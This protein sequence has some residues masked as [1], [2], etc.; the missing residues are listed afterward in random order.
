MGNYPNNDT[1]NRRNLLKSTTVAASSLFALGGIGSGAAQSVPTDA[2][3]TVDELALEYEVHPS[4][5][6]VAFTSV[7]EKESFQ[8]YVA[9][10]VRSV[11]DVPDTVVR[12]TD[13]EHG[14]HGLSWESRRVLQYSRDG[15]TYQQHIGS[16]RSSR[17]SRA[18]QGREILVDEEPATITSTTSW[19]TS[20]VRAQAKGYKFVKCVDVPVAG[21]W[22]V[23]IHAA[24]DGHSPRCRSHS[25]PSLVHH[26]IVHL[27][28]QSNVHAGI[29]IW[30][31]IT[32]GCLYAGEENWWGDCV[33]ICKD[34][35][36]LD[37]L[38]NYWKEI[39]LAG[40]A[41]AGIAFHSVIADA[42]AYILGTLS[43]KPPVLVP[44]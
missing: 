16:I 15:A 26:H 3:H 20:T 39:L 36:N 11:T 19:T 8:L 34:D 40:T 29:N 35:L 4:E 12:R 28:P 13:A 31:G 9:K 37:T 7:S 41:A 33:R 44:V 18:Q 43:L 42:I 25:V 17:R 5:P 32:G 30:A 23:R 6:L 27:F 10:G 38:A 1:L 22:C 2:E 21:G 14:V 24:D